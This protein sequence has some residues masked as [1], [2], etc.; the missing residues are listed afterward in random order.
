MVPE[1]KKAA[2]KLKAHGVK[3]VAVNCDE[4]KAL[5]QEMGAP[6]ARRELR[7]RSL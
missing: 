1:Y 4:A 2:T 5:A 3:V 7:W 6:P